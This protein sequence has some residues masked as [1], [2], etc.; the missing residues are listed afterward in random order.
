MLEFIS[1]ALLAVV[2]A[3]FYG[4]KVQKKRD[5][6]QAEND[7][8]KELQR[9]RKIAMENYKE[10]VKDEQTLQEKRRLV[11]SATDIELS[12]LLKEATAGRQRKN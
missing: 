10:W 11:Y 12:K 4:A 8:L 5:R 2:S 1:A 9:K 7:Y 3:F 6:T